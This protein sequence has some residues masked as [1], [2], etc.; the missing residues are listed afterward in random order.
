[1]RAR[2]SWRLWWRRFS[3]DLTLPAVLVAALATTLMLEAT[4]VFLAYMI[5]VVDQSERL[6]IARNAAIVYCS[7]LLM[8]VAAR[9]LL[10]RWLI[11]GTVMVLATSRA[12]LQFWEDPVARMYLGAAAVVVWGWLVIALLNR[13]RDPAAFGIGLGLALDLTIRL[14]Y[15]TVDLPWMPTAS[16]HLL[17]VILIAGMLL[18]TL[19]LLRDR[20]RSPFSEAGWQANSSLLALGPGLALYHLVTGNLGLAEV[21]FDQSLGIVGLR[22]SLAQIV[23]VAA[24]TG[25]L[26]G[27]RRFDERQPRSRWTL[28]AC[29]IGLTALGAWLIWRSPDLAQATGMLGA[30]GA[31]TLFVHALRGPA[32]PAGRPGLI[33]TAVWVTAG[34]ALQAA[35]V[36][37]YYSETGQPR[38]MTVVVGG[39]IAGALLA[40]APRPVATTPHI[41]RF[42]ALSAIVLILA[43]VVALRSMLRDE[44]PAISIPLAREMTVVTYNIQAG[45]SRDN[46]WSLERI[47]RTIEAQQPDIVILQEVS[48]GW[49]ILTGID[50]ARWLSQRLDMPLIFGAAS[51]DGLWGNAI[52]TRAPVSSTL[53]RQFTSTVN[54]HRSAVGAQIETESGSIWVFATHLDNP[55]EAGAVRLEQVEQLLALWDGKAPAVIGG[56]FNAPP[57]SDV[58][59]RI[60][61]AGLVDTGSDLG[62]EVT[63][64][65][66]GQR[67]DYIFVTPDITVRATRIPDVWTSD[68]KPVVAELTLPPPQQEA[69]R[70]SGARSDT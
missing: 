61:A 67:I 60:T 46:R 64:S 56:D 24:G 13:W 11:S 18:A 36:F 53:I 20:P 31:A 57:D 62:P 30:F 5:V 23:G 3:V 34:L 48:R 68:H 32:R 39:L 50:Q 70:R 8:A 10:P 2:W 22:L 6:T 12:I 26:L 28:L 58:V 15:T 25:L 9:W 52:L 35:T 45:F 65:E 55:D 4:R 29:V 51:R 19:P 27:V 42:A 16:Q 21:R 37:L 40:G 38:L 49:F 66:R 59:V 63:T 33:T 54:L 14:A 47:A 43:V 69:M 7:P 41:R 1:M 44:E 17:S